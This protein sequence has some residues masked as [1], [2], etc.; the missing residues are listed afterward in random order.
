MTN[1]PDG[2]RPVDV[3][4]AAPPDVRNTTMTLELAP[5]DVETVVLALEEYLERIP[6]H[7]H[8]HYQT[9]INVKDYLAD[10][11]SQIRDDR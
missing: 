8:P 2:T 11:L 7:C 5:N 4:R 1:L 6:S 10:A 9:V 3:D